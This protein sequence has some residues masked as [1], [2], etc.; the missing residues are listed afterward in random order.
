MFQILIHHLATILFVRKKHSLVIHIEALLLSL[1][2]YLLY[3]L[4]RVKRA[5]FSGA[6]KLFIELGLPHEIVV[7]VE[8]FVKLAT[9]HLG[10]GGSLMLEDLVIGAD[11][12]A[13]VVHIGQLGLRARLLMVT[14]V[15]WTVCTCTLTLSLRLAYHQPVIIIGFFLGLVLRNLI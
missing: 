3:E 1:H 14:L 7:L 9:F 13:I 11:L 6:G 10:V 5:I 15:Q 2:L 8:L 12:V 4:T